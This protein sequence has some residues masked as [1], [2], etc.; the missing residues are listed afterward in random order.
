VGD[1]VAEERVLYVTG[2]LERADLPELYE[3]ACQM[4]KAEPAGVVVCDA[5]GLAD[6]DA[7]ALEALARLVLAARRSGASVRLRNAPPDLQRLVDLSG[8]GD[9]MPSEL[10]LEP[11]RKSEEREQPHGVEEEVRPDDAPV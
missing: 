7:V 8:L 1:S 9:V 11:G 10:R 4:L 5:G 6:P 2:R 3:T